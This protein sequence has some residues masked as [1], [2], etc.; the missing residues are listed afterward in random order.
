MVWLCHW[1]FFC[2]SPIIKSLQLPPKKKKKF[3]SNS[4]TGLEEYE[5]REIREL[6]PVSTLMFKKCGEEE[7]RK[8][9]KE[10]KEEKGGE[11]GRRG[12]GGGRINDPKKPSFF[13][14][15]SFS[16]ILINFYLFLFI[17]IS[18]LIDFFFFFF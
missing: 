8:R 17:F 2:V 14:K 3:I 16:F 6:K 18:F 7:R 11:G 5:R 9:K 1:N 4:E 15:I 12:R 10:E 13:F